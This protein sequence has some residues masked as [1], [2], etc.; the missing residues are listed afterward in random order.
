MAVC[1]EIYIQSYLFLFIDGSLFGVTYDSIF[2]CETWLTE[3][4]LDGM[5]L[6]DNNYN[7]CRNDRS[8]NIRSGGVCEFI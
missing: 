5:L 7:L 8:N 1:I 2:M 4:I 3:H 6:Y